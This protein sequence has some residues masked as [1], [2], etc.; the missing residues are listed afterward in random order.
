MVARWCK[1][2]R[3]LSTTFAEI[4][5]GYFIKTYFSSTDN[6]FR[7]ILILASKT[8]SWLFT[9]DGLEGHMMF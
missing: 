7:E 8:S 1:K 3:F 5:E 9:K 2:W 6:F 4:N